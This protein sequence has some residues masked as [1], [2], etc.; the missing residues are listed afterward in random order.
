MGYTSEI[1]LENH[2]LV[3]ENAFPIISQMQ[4]MWA[5]EVPCKADAHLK[6]SLGLQMPPARLFPQITLKRSLSHS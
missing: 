1:F 3:K 2:S 4:W 5:G 6:P